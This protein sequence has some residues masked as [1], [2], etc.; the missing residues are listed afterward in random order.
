MDIRAAI[1]R[2]RVLV[3]QANSE[4]DPTQ[5]RQLR[6]AALEIATQMQQA[7][8]NGTPE[9]V[10]ETTEDAYQGMAGPE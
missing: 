2:R 10:P 8:E 7:L 4:T 6:K 3:Q 5:R 9:N 1:A